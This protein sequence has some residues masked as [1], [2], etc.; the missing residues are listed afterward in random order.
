MYSVCENAPP[1]NIDHGM[2]LSFVPLK[3]HITRENGRTHRSQ[4]QPF[5][6]SCS[7]SILSIEAGDSKA[8]VDMFNRKH[9]VVGGV[10]QYLLSKD[11]WI[12]CQLGDKYRIIAFASTRDL[13]NV[14][15]YEIIQQNTTPKLVEIA[16]QLQ[17]WRFSHEAP[18]TLIVGELSTS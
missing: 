13:M 12:G 1:L 6:T 8:F 15:G 11:A 10:K 4:I 14:V 18:V 16:K 17:K 2:K 5:V 9:G 3:H 7:A